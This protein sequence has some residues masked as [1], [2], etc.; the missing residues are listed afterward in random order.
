MDFLKPR[1]RFSNK[2]SKC[3]NPQTPSRLARNETKLRTLSQ[4]LNISLGDVKYETRLSR[5]KSQK[6][7]QTVENKGGAKDALVAKL[8]ASVSAIKAAYA[9]LQSAQF[10]YNDEAIKTADE[11][12]VSELMVLSEIKIKFLRDCLDLPPAHVTLML[13]EIQE[14]QSNIKTYEITMKQMEWKMEQKDERIA[15][16]R[17]KFEGVTERIKSHEKRLNSSGALLPLRGDITLLELNQCHFIRVLHHALRSLRHF[18]KHVACTME[19][20]DW[21]IELVA[22]S[23]Q[24]NVKF[25][26]PKH[27][28]YAIESYVAQL[29]FDGFNHDNF[30][31]SDEDG[32]TSKIVNKREEFFQRFIKMQALTTTRIFKQYPKCPFARFCKGKYLRV[33]HPKMECSFFGNLDQRKGINSGVFPETE[34]FSLFAETARRVWLLHCLAMSFDPPAVAF[35]VKRGCRFSEVYMES[36]VGDEGVVTSGEFTAAFTVVPGFKIGK[37]VVQSLV[38]A[39]PAKKLS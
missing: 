17:R 29:M 16:L 22:K 27:R 18:V 23:I 39:S 1:S 33:I 9:E 7:T 10:P 13:A 36:V 32:S 24:P 6:T 19:S 15:S 20:K 37:T 38:Y 14:Q 25:G 30:S 21:D 31:V 35:Q 2:F 4:E 3:I 12:L 8:F 28:I 5:Q 34:F 11:D 26:K